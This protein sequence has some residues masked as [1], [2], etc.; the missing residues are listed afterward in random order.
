MRAVTASLEHLHFGVRQFDCD[1]IQF[2]RLGA[3]VEPAVN[4]QRRCCDF[5]ES[6][7][8][9]IVRRSGTSERYLSPRLRVTGDKSAP[10]IAAKF[11]RKLRTQFRT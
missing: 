7:A 1:R 2:A 6:A 8:I 5:V 4:E 11:E 9:K 10:M 3:R